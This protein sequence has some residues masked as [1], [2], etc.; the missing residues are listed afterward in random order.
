MNDIRAREGA[1]SF[2]ET[3]FSQADSP[4]VEA[5]SLAMGIAGGEGEGVECL[6]NAVANSNVTE[7]AANDIFHNFPS[8]VDSLTTPADVSTEPGGDNAMYT[9]IRMPGVLNTIEGT[10][11]YI[12]DQAGILTHRFFEKI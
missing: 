1:A 4:A 6:A 5:Q 9:H 2:T 3:N 10:Y 12:I 8:L 7:V 11:H